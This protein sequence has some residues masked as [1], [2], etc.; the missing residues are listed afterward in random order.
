ML[1]EGVGDG[2]KAR[3][4][5]AVGHDA[6]GIVRGHG[7]L[8]TP[9]ERFADLPGYPFAPHYVD[10]P[11]GDGGNCASTTSTKARATARSC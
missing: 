5:L 3:G 1:V 8:R 10:V 7:V 6:H 2:F 9:D 11:D 4:D